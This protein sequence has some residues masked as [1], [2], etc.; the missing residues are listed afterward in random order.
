M[1]LQYYC[2]V[3]PTINILNPYKH[4]AALC[5][6]AYAQHEYTEVLDISYNM[7]TRGL[8][9]IYI[10]SALRPVALRPSVYISGKLL[11]PMVQLLHM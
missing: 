2:R 1:K 4:L 10:P 6:L 3:S 5:W 9:D 7:C 11:V 8:Y